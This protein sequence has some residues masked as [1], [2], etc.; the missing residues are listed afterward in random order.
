MDGL[1]REFSRWY[2]STIESHEMHVM[3]ET[4]M[5]LKEGEHERELQNK[6][7]DYEQQYSSND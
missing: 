6:L 5:R 3:K 7:V 4:S 2:E 1:T